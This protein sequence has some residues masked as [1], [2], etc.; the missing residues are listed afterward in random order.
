MAEGPEQF[1]DRK[2]A[3]DDYFYGTTANAWLTGQADRLRPGMRALSVADGEGRNAVWLAGQGLAVTAVDASAR[4][5][6]KAQALAAARGVS[7]DHIQAD[8]TR[9]AWPTAAFD[10]AVAIFAHFTPEH[11]PAIHRR[12]LDALVPGGLVLIE[13]YSPFQHLHRTGGPPDLDMLYTAWRLEQDFK[14]AEIQE[15]AEVTTELR[16]GRG[17]NGTSAVVRLVARRS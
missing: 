11:R 3:D 10:I 13:A 6:A 8:L 4:G 17:H 12:M 7:V 2:Y 1:W 14:G 16:E 9:W 15:L 5:I